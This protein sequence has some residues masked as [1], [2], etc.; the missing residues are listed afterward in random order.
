MYV[1]RMLNIKNLRVLSSCILI[2]ELIKERPVKDKE[3]YIDSIKNQS[4]LLIFFRP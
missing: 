3:K 1:Y 4:P 2:E